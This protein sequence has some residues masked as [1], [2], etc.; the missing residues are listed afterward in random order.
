M[1][2]STA[3]GGNGPETAT[4]QQVADMMRHGEERWPTALPAF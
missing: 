2:W 1:N 4:L 3:A